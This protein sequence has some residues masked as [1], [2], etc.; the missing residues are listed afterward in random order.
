MVD[1]GNRGLALDDVDAVGLDVSM[2]DVP[3]VQGSQA[4]QKVTGAR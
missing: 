2:Q 4:T 3:G 1:L